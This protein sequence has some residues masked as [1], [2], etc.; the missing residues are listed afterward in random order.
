MLASLGSPSILMSITSQTSRPSKP[1]LIVISAPSGAGK[2]T[3]CQKLLQDFPELALSISSTTRAPRG[4]EQHGKE[5]YFLTKAEFEAQIA[6]GRFAEWALVHGNYYGTSKDTIERTFATGKSVLLD[7]DVQG[8]ASLRKAF[9]ERC[10]TL[11]IA[12]PSLATLES[13][14]RARKTDSEETIQKRVRN[15]QNE[16]GRMP[17]FH[18]VVIN[19]QL[20]AAYA[21][22]QA[23]VA[24][25]LRPEGQRG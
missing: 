22:L 23:I 21:E 6:A 19:D 15:A 8:A 16:M 2:T 10:H 20:D 1:K 24:R 12:P 18:E 7:I 13:R 9:P 25:R 4:T 14:L 17:E 3:L 5:Y 11:F